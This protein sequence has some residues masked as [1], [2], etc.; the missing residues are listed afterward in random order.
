VFEFDI[1]NSTFGIVLMSFIL[2]LIFAMLAADAAWWLW[3]DRALRR[4]SWWRLLLSAFMAMQAACVVW[5]VLGRLVSERMDEW[6]PRS[7]VAAVFIWHFIGLP[8]AV[9][10][11]CGDG[12]AQLIDVAWR[13]LRDMAVKPDASGA[14]LSR[15]E[16]I[17]AALVAAPPVATVLATGASLSQLSGFRVRQIDVPIANL[18]ITLDGLRIAHVSDIHVGRFTGGRVLRKIIEATN[19]LHADVVLF[20]GDLINH[21]LADLPA[22][23]DMLRQMKS[24]GGV[25]LCEG[26]HDLIESRSGFEQM[27]KQSSLPLLLD[28]SATIELRGWPVQI[29]GL[30]WARHEA[31]ILNS[32]NALL[33]QIQAGAFPIL[34]AHHPHAFDPAAAAGIPLTLS[35]H[36]HG[37]QIM[38]S[39]SVGFG[40]IMFKYWSGL[41][42]QN[43]SS[44]VVSNGVGN[45]FPLRINAPAEIVQVT[46]RRVVG[47][48]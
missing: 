48:Q 10:I 25:F 39:Q 47:S 17:T 24:P 35:G 6:L 36:T 32:V 11:A 30:R 1:R 38:A 21:A 7:V 31:G 16:L 23:I 46:L 4:R 29:M 2:I 34:L 43:M 8:V 12:M 15:R 41:Y 42:R 37:G 20:T 3:A 19:D 9:V 14:G 26:N 45:W 40:P 27:V 18:P 22:G 28:E 44:L 33:P 13:R 5:I